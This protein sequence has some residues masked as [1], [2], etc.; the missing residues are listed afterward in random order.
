M[1]IFLLLI[2]ISAIIHYPFTSYIQTFLI[3]LVSTVAFDLAFLK[4]RRITLFF[5]YAAIVT[6]IIIGLTTS[7]NL[8]WYQLITAGGL[9]MFSKHYL[10]FGNRHIFNPAAFGLFFSHLVFG[11]NISW[12]AVSW[13][14]FG[15]QNP[16]FIIYPL[17]LLLPG[18]VS[19]VRMRRFVNVLT[20]YLVYVLFTKTIFDPTVIFFSL[21]MLPEP[22]TTPFKRTEQLLF[23]ISVAFLSFIIRLPLPDIFIPVLLLGNLMFFGF[24]YIILAKE[25]G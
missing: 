12:W 19:A 18:L 16:Q 8:S 24:R 20:F 7:L 25:R 14:Q 15:T 2:F 10:G 13:Q 6:G 21:V 1:A 22:M 11:E 5:P 3:A 9:A 4:L 23:G 17:I